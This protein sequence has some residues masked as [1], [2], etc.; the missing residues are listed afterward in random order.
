MTMKHLKTFE[1]W[2]SKGESVSREEMIDHL[3]KCGWESH[4]LDEMSSEELQTM[5]KET[6]GMSSEELT[7][8]KKSKYWIQD[9]IKRPGA[10]RRKLHK[11]K[12]E[13]VSMGE[14][15]SELQ[16]LKAKDKDKSKPG[17][18]GLSKRDLTKYRELNL[19]KTLKKMK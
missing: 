10:L 6:D 2:G 16:S 4:E 5:Y 12:G 8:A 7:E 15:D 11:K 13:K 19:A 17:V 9:A 1:N 18:Q 3:C 14:I